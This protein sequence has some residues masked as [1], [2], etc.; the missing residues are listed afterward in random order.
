MD[1]DLNMLKTVK[2]KHANPV[3]NGRPDDK[4][5]Y[6]TGP[7]GYPEDYLLIYKF[8]GLT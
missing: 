3:I 5:S 7:D 1:I 4:I 6:G 2:F 8:K